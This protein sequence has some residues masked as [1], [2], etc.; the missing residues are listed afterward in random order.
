MNDDRS[1]PSAG[2]DLL[3][4]IARLR[5]GK[6]DLLLQRL[7][8]NGVD[9]Q[10]LRTLRDGGGE[11]EIELSL[12]QQRLWFMQQLDPG[13][14]LYNITRAWWLQG[15]LQLEWLQSALAQL[16]SRHE[17]L[18]TA[19]VTVQGRPCQRL[20]A[21]VALPLKVIDLRALPADRARAEALEN[22]RSQATRGFDLTRP[23]LL[24]VSLYRVTESLQLLTVVIHH[25]VADGW[26]MTVFCRELS[27]LYAGQGD[28]LKALPMQYADYAQWQRETLQGVELERQLSYWRQQLADLSPLELP[29]DRP[30]PPSQSY[31]GDR[32]PVQLSAELNA[33]LQQLCRRQRVTPYMLLLAAFQLLLARYSGQHDVAV[34]SPIAGRNRSEFE[35]LIGCFVNT[36]VLRS[37][38]GGD[39]PFTELLERVRDTALNAYAHSDI[40]FEKLVEVLKP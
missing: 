27:T 3:A 32:H 4:R 35:G 2:A 34:G 24:R 21:E 33:G 9:P 38:L 5:P 26:S 11:P 20:L 39:P 31:R 17:S 15:T 6:R 13:G 19:L 23:P 18:R 29:T 22:A 25:L 7:S 36:L 40:P 1:A 28:Q 30:R 8:S 10:M 37:D 14:A 16:L 12:A